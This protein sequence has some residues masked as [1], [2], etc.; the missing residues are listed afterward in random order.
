LK[1]YPAA[2]KSKDQLSQ[3]FWGRAIFDF[4]NSIRQKLPFEPSLSNNGMVPTPSAI[5]L[6]VVRRTGCT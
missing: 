6:I 5:S 2:E 3:D 1:S 4:F